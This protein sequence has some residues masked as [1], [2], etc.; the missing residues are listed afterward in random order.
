MDDPEFPDK[1]FHF[2]TFACTSASRSRIHQQKCESHAKIYTATG[3]RV[4]EF[5]GALLVQAH[6]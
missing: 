4:R 6:L 3:A 1:L 5:L 2:V